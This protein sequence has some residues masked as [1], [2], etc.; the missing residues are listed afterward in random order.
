MTNITIAAALYSLFNFIKDLNHNHII[1]IEF[2]FS[3]DINLIKYI[4]YMQ[5]IKLED[6]DQLEDLFF[7]L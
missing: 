2:K 6:F 4:S 5:A 7:F 1:L 3:T